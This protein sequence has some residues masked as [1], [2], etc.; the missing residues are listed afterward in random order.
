MLSVDMVEPK[1]AS[2]DDRATPEKGS[3]GS[4]PPVVPPEGEGDRGARPA[5]SV[6]DV[7]TRPL[8]TGFGFTLSEIFSQAA[9]DARPAAQERAKERSEDPGVALAMERGEKLFPDAMKAS[10]HAIREALA[11]VMPV[12]FDSFV[13]FGQD[14]LARIAELVSQVS[15]MTEDVHRIDAAQQIHGIVT[16]ADQ[17]KGKKSLLDR[18]GIHKHFDP[19]E[20]GQQI[21]AIRN[22]LNAELYRI[23]KA[24]VD[25]ER[26]M[27]P[28]EVAV[29]VSGILADMA[30]ESGIHALVARKVALFTS[31]AAEAGMAKKQIEN[32]Q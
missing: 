30:A 15:A 8:N 16:E 18:M 19:A 3:A 24:A 17:A 4:V 32:L 28:L 31:S 23:R 7:P 9:A 14:Y 12:T 21:D 26:A 2:G 1:S 6:P 25:F 29:A 13:N 11:S 22:A 20:A 27:I 10:G 5:H